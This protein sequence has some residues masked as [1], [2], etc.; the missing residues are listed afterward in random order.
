MLP[1]VL[2]GQHYFVDLLAFGSVLSLSPEEWVSVYLHLPGTSRNASAWSCQYGLDSHQHLL[3]I[4]NSNCC[5][6]GCYK[7]T[8]YIQLYICVCVWV[9]LLCLCVLVCL[10]H[11]LQISN[12][13]LRAK[14]LQIKIVTWMICYHVLFVLPLLISAILYVDGMVG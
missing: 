12:A 1:N 9:C 6:K 8:L 4:S 13:D 5:L 10:L 2:T 14:N 3:H 11:Y 7:A